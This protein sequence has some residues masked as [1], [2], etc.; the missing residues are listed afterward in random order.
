MERRFIR[1]EAGAPL[2]GALANDE[3]DDLMAVVVER[4]GRVVGL[5][6]PRS[7]LWTRYRADRP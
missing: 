5:V 4:K 7:G 2:V 6:P 1:A 3:A